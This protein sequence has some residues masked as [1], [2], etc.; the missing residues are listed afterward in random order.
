VPKCFTNTC[1]QLHTTSGESFLC[2]TFQQL[3]GCVVDAWRFF[4]NAARTLEIRNLT[5]NM[6]QNAATDKVKIQGWKCCK[7]GAK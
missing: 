4:R 2:P 1:F 7:Y 3:T 6:L 5:L